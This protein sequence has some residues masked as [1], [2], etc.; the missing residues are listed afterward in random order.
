MRATWAAFRTD[1][2]QRHHAD[3]R[4]FGKTEIDHISGIRAG[5]AS[6]RCGSQPAGLLTAFLGFDV[7]GA[8]VGHLCREWLLWPSGCLVFF[9]L[10]A[11]LE[12]FHGLAQIGTHIAQLLGAEDQHHDHQQNCPVPNTKR[13]HLFPLQDARALNSLIQKT[14][15]TV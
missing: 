9:A 15:A 2:D 13:T 4:E 6:F 8:L 11:V 1:D 12:A 10:D 7:D 3:D 5:R 14:P